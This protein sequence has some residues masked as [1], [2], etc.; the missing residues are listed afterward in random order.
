METLNALV[1][2]Q[3][4]HYPQWGGQF[5]FATFKPEYKILING[6]KLKL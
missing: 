5:K 3:I 4:K 2:Y 6:K 1:E